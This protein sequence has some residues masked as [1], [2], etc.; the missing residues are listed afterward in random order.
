[1]F[2]YK[3]LMRIKP[4]GTKAETEGQPLRRVMG[5]LDLTFLGVGAIIGTGIFVLT[6]VASALYAGPAVV[7]SFVISGFAATLAALCYAELAAMDPVAGSA[8]SFTYS[9][10]G[11]LVAWLIGWN[12][13]LEYLVSAGAVAVGWSSYFN[14][15]LLSVGVTLPQALT[16]SVF[17][18]G[19]F[20]L[21]AVVVTLLITALSMVG[22]KGS[23]RATRIVVS[24]K[25]LVI[26]LFIGLG[27]AHVKAANW[28]P[29]MPFGFSGVIR[30][31]AIVFF[32]YIGFDA[33]STAAEDVKDPKR[34][35]QRGIIASLLIST[36]LYIVVAAVL[37][38]MRKYTLLD[39][40]SPISSALYGAGIPWASAII[41]VGALAGLTSVLIAVMFAQS[42]IFFAM[43]R[44]GLLPPVFSKIHRKYK[45]PFFDYLIIG[46][47]I[48]LVGAFLP[49]GFIAQM[50][51]IGTLSAFAV[52]AVGV[53]V[54]RRKKP[55][56]ERPFRV[57]WVPFLPALSAALSVYLMFNLPLATWIRFFVW[58]A[59]GLVIYFAYGFLHSRLAPERP[60]GRE[61]LIPHAG[62]GFARS[63]YTQ[64]AAAELAELK[65]ELT[66]PPSHRGKERK[67]RRFRRRAKRK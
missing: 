34:D 62:L 24:V 49:V 57:P 28:A 43:S 26:A 63:S 25:L 60:E 5:A 11:E 23:A 33:V 42:R 2:S 3:D 8:Y 37:T 16:K 46:A 30:G 67:V 47:A 39:T 31:A 53:I 50:A 44:D 41:S 19:V 4:I 18:G 21:F 48:C 36:V 10:L 66:Y 45:T 35:L 27:L 9:S 51:N 64:E 22:T 12:M 40:P 17:E 38:G 58:M 7:L 1:M 29:F 61:R 20:N 14:D 15:L 6:G 65:R 32:A 59:V 13:I 52:V 56:L 55:E 54:L